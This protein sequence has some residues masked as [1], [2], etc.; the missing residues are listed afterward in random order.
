MLLFPDL[1]E[2]LSNNAGCDHRCINTNGSY[3]CECDNGFELL[4]D[5][6]TCEGKNKINTIMH[7]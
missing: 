7:A 3:Y 6:H 5:N 1:N 4:S 2:C